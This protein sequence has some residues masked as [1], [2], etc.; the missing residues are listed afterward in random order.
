MRSASSANVGGRRLRNGLDDV[1]LKSVLERLLLVDAP[2]VMR[3][4]MARDDQHRQLPKAGRQV[5]LEAN[6]LAQ[7][8]RPACELR[9]AEPGRHRRGRVPAKARRG[10]IVR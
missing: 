3:G 9:V 1:C 8:L 7:L 4:P 10:F 5:D 6:V 2:F